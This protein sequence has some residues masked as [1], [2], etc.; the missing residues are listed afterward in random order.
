MTQIKPLT[1]ENYQGSHIMSLIY[2]IDADDISDFPEAIVVD[3]KFTLDG[4]IT[5]TTGI[6]WARIIPYD[7]EAVL[8]APGQN[9][10]HGII[11]SPS[12]SFSRENLSPEVLAAINQ[13]NNRKLV[14]AIRNVYEEWIIVGSK[15]NPMRLVAGSGTDEVAG[16]PGNT[17][18]LSCQSQH[19]FYFFTGAISNPGSDK[20]YLKT[21]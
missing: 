4:N 2:A 16:G 6:S 8:S 15:K 13:L 9:S 3:D 18:S 10:D 19:P 11:Y 5:H 17:I 7:I 1:A 21:Y 12:I 14:V 20:N